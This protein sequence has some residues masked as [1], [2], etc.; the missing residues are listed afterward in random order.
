MTLDIVSNM[1]RGPT[2]FSPRPEVV[3][4]A[5]WVNPNTEGKRDKSLCIADKQTE[6]KE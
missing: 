5:G 1:L 2:E 4:N 3:G 6:A